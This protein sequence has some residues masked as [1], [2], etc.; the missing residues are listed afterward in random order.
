MV[1]A[2]CVYCV[3]VNRGRGSGSPCFVCVRSSFACEI[4]EAVLGSC[5]CGRLFR[6]AID[7]IVGCVGLGK[8]F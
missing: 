8:D 4:L 1:S 7:L 5:V 3:F 2:D 6:G